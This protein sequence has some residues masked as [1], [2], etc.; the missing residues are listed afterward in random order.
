MNEREQKQQAADYPMNLAEE[1][2][3]MN[4][5]STTDC[6]GLIQRPLQSEDERESY[7]EMYPYLAPAMK[8]WG[9]D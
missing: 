2:F 1:D 7:E 6:T 9:D 3:M 5:A 8:V 4:C